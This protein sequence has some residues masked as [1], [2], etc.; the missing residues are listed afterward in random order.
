MWNSTKIILSASIQ[1]PNKLYGKIEV[2]PT[3]SVDL[4]DY[5]ELYV[6]DVAQKVNLTP[7]DM[8]FSAEGFAG[9]EQYEIHIVAYPKQNI[10][11][12]EPIPSNRRVIFYIINQ[13][14]FYVLLFIR[15]L[16]SNDKFKVVHH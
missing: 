7:T 16:K 15:H 10:V 9:G 12:A 11:D 3:T 1:Y 6:D 8:K 14:R 13:Q 4:I 2:E 5:F